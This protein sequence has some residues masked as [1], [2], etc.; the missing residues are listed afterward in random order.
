MALKGSLTTNYWTNDA[1]KTRGYTLE[2]SATQSVFANLSTISWTVKTAGTYPYGVAERTLKVT[3][4]GVTLINKTDRVMRSAGTVSSGSFTLEHDSKGEL[5]ISGSI[6]AAVYVS[7]VNCKASGSWSLDKIARQ[8]MITSVNDFTDEENPVI[9]YSNPEGNGALSLQACISLDGENDDIPY[10]EI[11]L[12]GTSYTFEL[13]DEER[14]FLRISTVGSNS[15]SVYFILK[16]TMESIT[17]DDKAERTFTVINATPTLN[18]TITDINETT[19]AL[20]GNPSILVKEH[21]NAQVISGSEVY[22]GAGIK[23]EKI[24]CGNQSLNESGI[25]ENVGSGAFIFSLTDT[26]ENTVTHE[27]KVPLIEYVNLTCN[28]MAHAP[29]AEGDMNFTV[30]G[31][32]F[33]GTFGTADNEVLIYYRYKENASDFTEWFEAGNAVLS[34]NTYSLDVHLSGLD[35]RNKHTFQAMAEDKLMNVASVERV[36]KTIP[37]FDWGEED[38]NFNV[39]VYLANLMLKGGDVKPVIMADDG[40]ICLRPNGADDVT[41]EFRVYPTGELGING[42]NLQSFITEVGESNGWMYIKLSNGMAACFGGLA[43]ENLA[44]NTKWEYMYESPSI[45]LPD[46]PFAFSE[47][48]I[49]LLTWHSL[50]AMALI[51]YVAGVTNTSAGKTMLVRPNAVGSLN[52]YISM[53]YVGKWKEEG[54]DLI[55]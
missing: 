3:L 40:S 42:M 28:L 47:I 2:W 32:C 48:P 18:P 41:G 36:V 30:S 44:C 10:R 51:Q 49:P 38:F 12:S 54:S 24:I 9:N 1:G 13:T 46:F 39:P 34:N 20:T 15:L 16:T 8:A 11:D 25:I 37:V 21:S 31:N 17:L 4:G 6:E 45:A 23:S 35:Y 33:S 19:I 43:V 26:R 27:V 7:S 5:N 52:G 29:D 53:F 50:G 14:E 55:E 22:K